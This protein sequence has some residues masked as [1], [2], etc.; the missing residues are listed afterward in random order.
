MAKTAKSNAV[1][2]GPVLPGTP[3][4]ENIVFLMVAGTV[5]GITVLYK[6]KIKKASV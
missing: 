5:L 1:N 2:A 3:I 4:D 6:S